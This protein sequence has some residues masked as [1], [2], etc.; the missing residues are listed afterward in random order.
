MRL[1]HTREGISGERERGQEWG[2][3]PNLWANKRPDRRLGRSGGSCHGEC[4][5]PFETDNRL[6][7]GHLATESLDD[8]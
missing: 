8:G 1:L 6:G 4:E 3:S 5:F 2:D 7:G